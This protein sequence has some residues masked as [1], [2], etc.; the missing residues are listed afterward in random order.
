V[1]QGRVCRNIPTICVRASRHFGG[2]LSHVNLRQIR[3]FLN[4]PEWNQVKR[5]IMRKDSLFDDV[6]KLP[7]PVGVGL[8]A[9]VFFVFHTYQLVA[10]QT[11]LSQ[12]I[13]PAIRMLAY[14][15]IGMLLFAAFLSFLTQKIRSKRFKT[16][17]SMSD[18]RSLTW[19][20]T[21]KRLMCSASTG[22]P[23]AWVLARFGNCWDQ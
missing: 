9:F 13:F 12:A 4:S 1:R 18:L 19:R 8:A 23:P 11:Q 20:Q 15:F 21:V 2:Q 3:Y 5:G 14:I 6:M 7:W 22:R 17:R 16:T 10:P